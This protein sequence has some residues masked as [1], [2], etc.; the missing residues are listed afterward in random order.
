LRSDR[1]AWLSLLA[2]VLAAVVPSRADAQ[3][4]EPAQQVRVHIGGFPDAT[5]EQDAHGDGIWTPVC[6]RP[7]N[8]LLPVGPSYQVNGDGI[9]SS[10]PFQLGAPPG[11]RVTLAVSPAWTGSF[12]F[13]IVLIPIGATASIAGAF[14][15]ALAPLAS[16]GGSDPSAPPPSDSSA[17]T[18]GWSLVGLGA[19]A[20]VGGVLLI[21][22]NASTSVQQQVSSTVPTTLASQ[23]DPWRLVPQWRESAPED[24]AM[25]RAMEA[26][27]WS[28]RF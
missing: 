26:P 9:R 17:L 22:S 10:S 23:G 21:A 11:G 12:V 15:V 2:G 25:P 27:V 24:A 8:M 28:V 5:L 13:G 20:L 14:V 1:A 18:L 4:R 6:S 19:V 7:C 3:P 16:A